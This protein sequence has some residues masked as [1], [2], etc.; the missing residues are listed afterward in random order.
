MHIMLKIS[1]LN[2]CLQKQITLCTLR[3]KTLLDEIFSLKEYFKVKM[4]LLQESL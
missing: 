2:I 1:S 3:A 4:Q